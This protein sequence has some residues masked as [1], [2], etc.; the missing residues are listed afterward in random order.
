M[1]KLSS[2]DHIHSQLIFSKVPAVWQVPKIIF[3]INNL[4]EEL[5]MLS[6]V[7]KLTV[8]LYYNGNIHIKISVGKDTYCRFQK[9]SRCKLPIV[10]FQWSHLYSV[11]FSQNRVLSNTEVYLTHDVLELYWA[12]EKYAWQTT[13]VTAL[14]LQYPQ[15]SRWCY[16]VQ[17]YHY[18]MCF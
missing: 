5:I 12:P 17:S 15:R 16:M 13:S 1:K 11:C 4:L 18:K 3:R 9:S 2:I 8:I 6:E 7:V 10:F 14:S